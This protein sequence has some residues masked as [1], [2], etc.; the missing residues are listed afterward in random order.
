MVHSRTHVRCLV[1]DRAVAGRVSTWLGLGSVG[2][3]GCVDFECC[4][5]FDTQLRIVPC[6]AADGGRIEAHVLDF[7]SDVQRVWKGRVPTSTLVI[8]SSSS[9]SDRMTGSTRG[10][11]RGNATRST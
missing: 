2:G 11:A 4:G 6:Q 7:V 1:D 5:E 8:I 9:V 10:R 3:G